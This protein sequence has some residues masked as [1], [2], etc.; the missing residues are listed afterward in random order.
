M[1]ELLT[2][3]ELQRK[4]RAY[5]SSLHSTTWGQGYTIKGGGATMDDCVNFIVQ[6]IRD[7]Q[8]QEVE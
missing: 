2:D 5:L 7:V 6:T 4:V 3:E 1:A 8:N